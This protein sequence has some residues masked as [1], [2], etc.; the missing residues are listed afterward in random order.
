MNTDYEYMWIVMGDGGSLPIGVF[1]SHEK[2]R[3]WIKKYKIAGYLGKFPVDIGVYDWLVDVGYF[4]PEKH[5]PMNRQTF[6]SGSLEHEHFEATDY[7][8]NISDEE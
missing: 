1:S 4:K 8:K 6:A 3:K 7:D 2:A 5:P